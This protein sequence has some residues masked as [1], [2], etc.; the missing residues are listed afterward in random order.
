MASFA[1]D[2]RDTQGTSHHTGGPFL[3]APT[4]TLAD[5]APLMMLGAGVVL[6]VAWIGSLSWLSLRLLMLAV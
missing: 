2:A 3:A 5:L 4:S 6:T 1:E